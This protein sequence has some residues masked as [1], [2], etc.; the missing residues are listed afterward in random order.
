MYPGPS[1]GLSNVITVLE[2]LTESM[3]VN[4][5]KKLIETKGR[6]ADL[7][8][9]GYLFEMLNK[10]DF[11]EPIEAHLKS[12]YPNKIVLEP[13]NPSRDGEYSKRWKII[14]NQAIESDL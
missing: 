1:A 11:A 2:E 3:D 14:I 10:K 12:R 4:E 5:L 7:Q 6:I 9:L 13:R 8:R